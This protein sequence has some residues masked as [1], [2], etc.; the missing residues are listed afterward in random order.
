MLG[1]SNSRIR[2]EIYK[3][4]LRTFAAA[5]DFGHSFKELESLD[6]TSSQ[7]LSKGK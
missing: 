2:S 1:M 5:A 7:K 4:L 3:S 6:L